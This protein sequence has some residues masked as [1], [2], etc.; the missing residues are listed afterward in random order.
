[1]PENQADTDS[2]FEYDEAHEALQ[3]PT[4]PAPKPHHEVQV[5][6]RT[7]GDSGDYGYDMA[8]DM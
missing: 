3:G 2:D 6:T 1:V 5:H 4:R 7:E 8:H